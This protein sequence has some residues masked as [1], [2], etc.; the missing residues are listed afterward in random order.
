MRRRERREEPANHERWLV[1]YADFITLLFAFFVVMF[2]S[3]QVDQRKAGKIALS[4][5]VAFQELGIFQASSTRAEL[6]PDEAI[7]LQQLQMIE[8]IDRNISLQQVVPKVAHDL[9]TPVDDHNLLDMR[10]KLAA[11]LEKEMKRGDVLLKMRPD[12]LVI[13][14]Q[15]VGF[16]DSGSADL[17]ARSANTLQQIAGILLSTGFQV[18]IE[19][20]TDNVPIHTARF[21]S[22]WELSTARA[23]AVIQAL[24][25][26]Y[27]FPPQRLAV[28]GYGEFHPVA[29][30]STADGRKLN[31]RVDIVVTNTEVQP[32]ARSEVLGEQMAARQAEEKLNSNSGT[33]AR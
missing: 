29:S 14:L 22:N 27:S 33:V 2:A 31:R 26:R 16:F 32:P 1:S 8:N 30:N 3:S 21:T 18:R 7:P 6:N 10:N 20:H 13:S 9:S 4:V 12:G 19:G 5:Q 25:E 17:R 23:I 24:I 15:E 28:A 11:A